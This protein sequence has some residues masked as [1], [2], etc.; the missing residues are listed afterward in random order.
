MIYIVAAAGC[1][2]AGAVL[3]IS[4]PIIQPGNEFNLRW[5]AEMLFVS[6]IGAL[7]TIEGP[8]LGAIIFF[9]LQQSL[10]NWGAWYR[11]IFVAVAVAVSVA[12]WQPRGLWGAV[13]ER[14]HFELLPVGYRI[15]VDDANTTAGPRRLRR[16]WSKVRRRI[17]SSARGAGGTDSLEGAL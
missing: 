12:I 1:G 15:V 4:Q 7:G 14:F 17:G 3:A 5:A 16:L 9:V 2:A 13:R 10:Q 8:I 11:I 6:M